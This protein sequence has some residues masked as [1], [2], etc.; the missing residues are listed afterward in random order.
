MNQN[1]SPSRWKLRPAWWT[2]L[3][4]GVV[5]G[6]A[7]RV[8]FGAMPEGA[9]G[10]MSAAFL[11]GTPF[12]LGSITV[13]AC[14]HITQSWLFYIFGPWIAVV[15]ML[16]GCAV[17][18]LE[19]SICLVMMAPLFLFVASLGGVLTGA[20]M[21]FVRRRRSTLMSIVVLP[22]LIMM[23]EERVP[24]PEHNSVLV[25][26]V[27]IDAEPR[28]VWEQI[29]SARAIRRDELPLSLTH[30]MGV[31]RPV[32]GINI[33]T[34][35]GIV[36]FSRWE[37]GVNFAANVTESVP[38]RRI[39]WHYRFDANSFPEG[40]MDEHVEIGG[41]FFDLQDTEFN[42]L[43]LSGGRTR[44]EIVAHYRVTS[45]INFY[46]VPAARFIGRDFVDTILGLYKLRSERAEQQAQSLRVTQSEQSDE[47][48]FAAR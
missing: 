32:E 21:H 18:L 20:A 17:A 33:R 23:G 41:R 30:L 12:V 38:Y 8:L 26:S 27:V 2:W 4:G 29:V 43:P 25:S 6:I 1:D 35:E 15:L 13:F 16:A 5:Y 9:K 47:E 37:R 3:I 39:R 22:F 36:R 34:P 40:S 11:I 7:L 19:G 31:P 44:L 48:S 45:S 46:A 10:V 42:L 14:R 28:T 24:M